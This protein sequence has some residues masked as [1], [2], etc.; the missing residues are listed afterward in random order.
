MICYY[1]YYLPFFFPLF[2]AF[3]ALEDWNFFP[4]PAFF[5]GAL[6]PAFFFL[7]TE[8]SVERRELTFCLEFDMLVA[9]LDWKVPSS[10]ILS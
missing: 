8:S 9:G 10:Y 5:F 1:Y 7:D 4:D 6:L 3:R 2:A